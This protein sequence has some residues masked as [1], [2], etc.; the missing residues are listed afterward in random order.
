MVRRLSAVLGVLVLGLAACSSGGDGAEGGGSAPAVQS[1]DGLVKLL[2]SRGLGCS[3]F[4]ALEATLPKQLGRGKCVVRV[5]DTGSD[6]QAIAND[7]AGELTF[8]VYARGSKIPAYDRNYLDW[9]QCSR[10][11][12]AQLG[13]FQVWGPNWVG[14]AD[15]GEVV[16]FVA[17]A[18]GAAAR[19]PC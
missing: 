13:A 5:S 14:V 6:P 1:V 7:P 10:P 16:A 18:T 4:E 8:A 17:D 2:R 3:Q 12:T 15:E 19:Q 11:D 9:L